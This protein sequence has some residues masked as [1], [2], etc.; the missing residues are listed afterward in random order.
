M[1]LQQHVP[2]TDWY[3]ETSAIH[4]VCRYREKEEKVALIRE[5]SDSSDIQDEREEG[6]CSQRDRRFNL[7]S[8]GQQ[9]LLLIPLSLR[10]CY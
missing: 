7:L 4:T 1:T 8:L 6:I 3:A 2:S 10:L 9:G 5:E